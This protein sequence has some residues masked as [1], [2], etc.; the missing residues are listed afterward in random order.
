MS[1]VLEILALWINHTFKYSVAPQLG[2]DSVHFARIDYQDRAKR[3]D[4]KSL[5]VVWQGSKTFGSSSQVNTVTRVHCGHPCLK[6]ST[7]FA[8]HSL[9]PFADLCQCLSCSL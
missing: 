9:G 8:N 3:K 1:S 2:F 4:D 7:A 6:Y 5:E